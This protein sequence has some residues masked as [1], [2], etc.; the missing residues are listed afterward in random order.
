MGKTQRVRYFLSQLPPF[1]RR[2]DR[3]VPDN[4]EIE[5]L[6]GNIR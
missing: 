4:L 5:R 3:S 6:L 2:A 1:D